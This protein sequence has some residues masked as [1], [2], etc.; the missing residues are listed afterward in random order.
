MFAT[1][2]RGLHLIEI[3]MLSRCHGHLCVR[4]H[5]REWQVCVTSSYIDCI[6]RLTCIAA[7]INSTNRHTRSSL[8]QFTS[9]T[10]MVRRFD[11]SEQLAMRLLLINQVCPMQYTSKNPTSAIRMFRNLAKYRTIAE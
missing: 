6:N 9:L 5:A 10:L 2:Q 7:S 1:D 4:A 11:S 8:C 3:S